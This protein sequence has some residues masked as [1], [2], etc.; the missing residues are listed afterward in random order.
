ISLIPLFHQFLSCLPR[1]SPS[2]IDLSHPSLAHR[3]LSSLSRSSPSH[4]SLSSL[5]CS[6]ISLIPLLLIDL[7]HPS[8]AHP[9]LIDLSHPSLAHPP[10]SQHLSDTYFGVR[11]KCLQLLGCLGNVDTPLNKEGQGLVPAVIGGGAPGVS[12]GVC[13]RDAQSV[14]S[15]YFADQDPR[16]HQSHAATA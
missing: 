8:L 14:I 13:V 12:G 15:D 6:S 4:R 7:S 5:S 2:L 11:N 3:S 10:L 9:P 16:V 1:S